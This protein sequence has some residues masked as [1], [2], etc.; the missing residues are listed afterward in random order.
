MNNENKSS[1]ELSKD[2]TEWSE[3][4]TLMSNERTFNS[5]NGLGLGAIGVA[6]GLKAVFGAFEPT[7]F[8]KLAATLFLAIAVMVFWLAQRAAMATR[9]RLQANDIGDKPGRN[10]TLVASSLTVAT[11]A[12][13]IILWL[14]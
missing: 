9:K 6:I 13:A 4:R 7:W 2:R 12:V 5:W 1:Q 11:I 3:D 10:F 14:L 8:A